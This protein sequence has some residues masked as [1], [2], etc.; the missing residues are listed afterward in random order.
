MVAG[1]KKASDE[2]SQDLSALKRDFK[3]EWL[4]YWFDG[5]GFCVFLSTFN[6]ERPRINYVQAHGTLWAND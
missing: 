5:L 4:E 1:T 3:A 2:L 6:F